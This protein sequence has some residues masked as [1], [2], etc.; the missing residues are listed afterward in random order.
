MI[1]FMKYKTLYFAISS[2]FLLTG[3]VSLAMWGL[4][5]A[6]DFTGGSLLEVNIEGDVL[7]DSIHDAVS[8]IEGIDINSIQ[9]VNDS[10]AFILRMNPIDEAKKNEGLEALRSSD[11]TNQVTEVRFE[12]VGPT[13]GK[14]L[15]VKTGV[16]VVIASI[17]ILM[18]V[19]YQFKDK[20]YGLAAIFAMFHDTFILIGAFAFFGHF[21]NVE[22]D[23]LFVTAVLTTLSF[24]VHD[25]IVVFDRIRES[26]KL[27]PNAD[28]KDIVNKSVTET[29]SR[30]LNNSMTIIFMLTALALLG[31][32]TIRWFVV[33]LLIGTIAGTYSSTFTAA[34]LLLVL[35]RFSRRYNSRK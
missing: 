30:S 17:F 22:I 16:A 9:S 24:S 18:Y 6:I 3:G 13:L 27:R 15:L 2:V 26:L 14:E 23:I 20:M 12:T 25:T 29:L 33:A 10:N 7:A 11:N 35:R 34:P 8:G 32:D 19:A 28:F 5:P 21:F 1:D 4:R 31:G